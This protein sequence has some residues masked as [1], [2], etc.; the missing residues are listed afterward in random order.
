LNSLNLSGR[1]TYSLIEGY[2]DDLTPFEKEFVR[3]ALNY[4]E[5]SKR[6]HPYTM[7]NKNR[8]PNFHWTNDV[9]AIKLE[10]TSAVGGPCKHKL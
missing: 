8:T 6:N 3:G 2:V 9:I 1:A 4:G 7:F 10:F 5:P